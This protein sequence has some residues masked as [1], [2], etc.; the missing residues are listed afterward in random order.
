ML[1]C[2][3][4]KGLIFHA[5]TWCKRACTPDEWHVLFSR[6]TRSISTFSA[7]YLAWCAGTCTFTPEGAWDLERACPG[8]GGVVHKAWLGQWCWALMYAT[9]TR[10]ER[11]FKRNRCSSA[12]NLTKWWAALCHTECCPHHPERPFPHLP[13]FSR[14]TEPKATKTISV[15]F[16]HELNLHCHLSG[17]C[18]RALQNLLCSEPIQL[19]G[20]AR[21]LSSLQE[22]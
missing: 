11:H 12:S 14:C 13:S 5:L 8:K 21:F 16:N 1:R 22:S 19:Y 4:L 9:K 2:V 17:K 15:Q 18:D 3:L 10:N 7:L 20:L 6:C